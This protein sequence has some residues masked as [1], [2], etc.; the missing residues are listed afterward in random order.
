M[1]SGKILTAAEARK[2]AESIGGLVWVDH[3][4]FD[5]SD[6]QYHGPATFTP[7]NVGYY[8]EMV[9]AQAQMS[10]ELGAQSVTVCLNTITDIDFDDFDDDCELTNEYDECIITIRELING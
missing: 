5:P 10:L 3:T 4:S 2:I 1:K 7:A 8:L 9:D 6:L